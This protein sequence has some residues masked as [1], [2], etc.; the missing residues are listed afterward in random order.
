[1]ITKSKTIILGIETTTTICS[2]G[3]W[4]GEKMYQNIS[5]K[6]RSHSQRLLPMIEELLQQS[7]RTLADVEL[8]A[9]AQGPGSFTGLRIGIGVAKGLAYGQDIPLVAISPLAAIAYQAMQSSPSAKRVTAMLD[10]R[11]GELYVAHYHNENGYPMLLGQEKLSKLETVVVK[12]QLFAGTGVQAYLSELTQQQAIISTV[13]YPYASD[14]VT[15]AKDKNYPKMNA[16]DL[17]PVHLR[18]KVTH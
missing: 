1:M 2:V 8:I 17:K 10:A 11:M 4:D 5:E 15:L 18:D 13:V 16:M 14:V 12:D 7:D 6:A 9:C 3:L